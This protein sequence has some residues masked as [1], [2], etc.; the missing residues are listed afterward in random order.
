MSMTTSA[1]AGQTADQFAYWQA[2]L[3]GE[4]PDH[5]VGRAEAGY[6]RLRLRDG[7]TVPIFLWREEGTDRLCMVYDLGQ[8]RYVE[9]EAAF[10]ERTFAYALKN[11]VTTA[12]YK[13]Y[14]QH[15]RWPEDVPDV[16]AQVD[17]RLNEISESMGHNAPPEVV[18][19][20][21]VKE[22][23]EEA[24]R[25][26]KSIGGEIR[27]QADADKAANF[28]DRFSELEREAEK[29][30]VN[31][32]EP[33]LRASRDVDAKWQ[34]VKK[35][36]DAAKRWA[37][38][39]P[40]AF[41]KSERARKAA[42]AAAKAAEGQAVNPDDLKVKAGTRGRSVSLRG[43]KILKVTHP[44]ALW[45]AYA[46]DERFRGDPDVQSVLHRLAF[47]DLQLGKTVLGAEIITQ[48]SAK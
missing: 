32:K 16:S 46:R 25:W 3:R 28:A 9:D 22:L 19:S 11:P 37:K 30:R 29:V 47:G 33:H 15:Q 48:E 13:H 20:E 41:L 42:E 27:T 8:P 1:A 26:L 7:R 31:E 38:G 17:N 39:L 24:E 18:I 6:W 2:R 14:L 44:E 10:C 45:D 5:T 4:H 43:R 40:E 34:P 23:R 36:A 12:S 21:T 35:A